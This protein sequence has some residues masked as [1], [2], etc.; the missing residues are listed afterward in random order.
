MK[1]IEFRVLS[2][3]ASPSR[4]PWIKQ[5]GSQAVQDFME[6]EIRHG[7]KEGEKEYEN[8]G[9]AVATE[10]MDELKVTDEAAEAFYE[11]LQKEAC[12]G[13]IVLTTPCSCCQ[14]E[15]LRHA[16]KHG[17]DLVLVENGIFRVVK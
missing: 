7:L 13:K 11:Y 8:V 2:S 16:R 14:E 10:C 1:T 15:K 9:I 5:A 17:L 4:W 3:I 12:E 6:V